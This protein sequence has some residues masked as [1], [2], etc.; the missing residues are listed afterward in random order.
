MKEFFI[1][2]LVKRRNTMTTT[3]KKAGLIIA[4]V[5]VLF[6]AFL[7]LGAFAM[8]VAIGLFYLDA[9]LFGRMNVEFEYIF[10]NGDIDIDKIMNMQSRKRIF[11]TNIK[12]VEIMAPEGAVELRAFQGLKVLDF[13]SMEPEHKKYEMVTSYKGEKVRI[14]LEPNEAILDGMKYLAPRKVVI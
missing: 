14:I 1:E 3:L 9:F 11:S 10:Y 4:T 2:H 5:I 7:F 6:F 12:E 8:F 13:S